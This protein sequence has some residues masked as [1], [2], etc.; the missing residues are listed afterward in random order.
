VASVVWKLQVPKSLSSS[1]RCLVRATTL[2][3]VAVSTSVRALASTS[4]LPH[5]VRVKTI[6][7]AV[8]VSHRMDRIQVHPP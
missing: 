3:R 2:V 5:D 1:L 6:I 8:E 7:Q 4:L